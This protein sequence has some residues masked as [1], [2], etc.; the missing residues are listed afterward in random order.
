MRSCKFRLRKISRQA[1]GALLG[2]MMTL[3]VMSGASLIAQASSDDGIESIEEYLLRP[4]EAGRLHVDGQGLYGEDGS[5]V[6][7]QGPSTHGLTWYPQYVNEDLFRYVS[8]D[9]NANLIRL[10]M[11]SDVYC[12]GGE[13]DS[14]KLLTEG[15]EYAVDADMYVLV[16]WH[17]L[18]D[19]NPNDNISDAVDFFDTVSEMYAGTPN[20]LYEIC[21]EPNGDTTWEDVRRYAS[22]IIPIIRSNDPEAVIIVG[23]PVYD[24]D[25]SCAVENPVDADNVM[26]SF[27]FYA[28]SHKQDMRDELTEA[29]D[30]GLPVFVTE[31]GIS[32]ES[33]D[34]I[35]DYEEATEWFRLV[36]ERHLS[37]AVW[38][39][40]NKE[41]SSAMIRYDTRHKGELTD[42][43]LTNTGKWIRA[44]MRGEDT[45]LYVT[46]EASEVSLYQKMR[47][48]KWL[49]WAIFAGITLGILILIAVLTALVRTLRKKKNRTYDEL[50]RRTGGYKDEIAGTGAVQSTKEKRKRRTLL[51]GRISLLFTTVFTFIYLFWRM[52][53]SVPVAYG[54]LAV[55]CNLILLIV[56]VLGFAESLVHYYS[57]L[58]M[59]D[60]PLPH[61]EDD[62]YPD[63]DIFI[64]TYSEPTSLLKKTIIGCKHIIYPD[65]SKVHIYLCDDHRRP[66]MRALAEELGVNYFDRPD[67]EGAKAG[68]LNH[69]MSLTTSPYIVTLD[70][71]MIPRREFLIKTIPYYV[72]AGKR[73]AA[74]PEGE[75]MPLGLIQT[76][77]CFYNPDVFQYGLYN[78]R[79]IPNEQ[80]FFYRT[81]ESAKTYTNSVIYGG[82]NTILSRKALEDIGGFY[83][84]TITEDFATG[85][86]IESHG[87]VSLGLSEPLA[88]GLAPTTFKEHVQ[89][90]TRWGRGVILTGR[91]LKFMFNKDLTIQQKASYWS[92]VVYWYSPIK[93]MIYLVSPLLYALFSIPVFKCTMLDIV[94]FWLPMFI[95][96]NITLRAISSRTMTAK[97]SGIQET[98]VM[99]FLFMPILKE[100]FG[101][102]LST[103][104]VTNKDGGRVARKTDIRMLMPFIVLITLSV[105]AIVRRGYGFIVGHEFGLVVILFW[106]IRNLYFMLMGLFLVDGR[107]G[108]GENVH[109]YDA[110]PVLVGGSLAGVT[111]HLTEHSV[112]IFLD[113][114]DALKLGDAAELEIEAENYTLTLK[115]VVINVNRSRRS[116]V[117]GV[118]TLEITDFCGNRD[119]YIQMLYDRI[120]TLPQQFTGELGI[121]RD[122]WRNT[123]KR[124]DREQ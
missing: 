78:E 107:D 123:T 15:V 111:S 48:D 50:I 96:Q 118:Y 9:W 7:L 42:K 71:D 55:I 104:K 30:A 11:Y 20:V 72:D 99:P 62:E 58:N 25:L 115:G 80:D 26:Y 85:M 112:S 53:F 84:K 124:L 24:R 46:A 22:V 82:S 40:S 19:S 68:N 56:E 97:W 113:E 37:C 27:H 87:Y 54:W 79:H 95:C 33:G 106:L 69:A 121:I 66:E 105:I 23:T 28:S 88:S 65:L 8:E 120:P 1:L 51:I 75:R 98:A 70:A 41:E 114:A 73:N 45:S 18:E 17:V 60:H 6:I 64:S 39:L 77:Q 32:E 12:N 31:C 38:S 91:Q 2:I 16:D 100:T 57:M 14:M 108:D 92:S 122:L 52:A 93:N 90:R 76:P 83:T 21:N 3:A 103:F 67:N 119:E 61:I 29:L 101:I 102:S 10:A 47:S 86:L 74:L 116:N 110:E 89:Q 44:L 59:R 117:P 109:V 5:E 81:I 13:K 63:V 34:G 35:I 4:S 36:H 43:D 94:I 49:T